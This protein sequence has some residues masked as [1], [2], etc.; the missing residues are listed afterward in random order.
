MQRIADRIG[1]EGTAAGWVKGGALGTSELGAT[2]GVEREGS[3]PAAA[4]GNARS[5]IAA[6]NA[7]M[8]ILGMRVIIRGRRPRDVTRL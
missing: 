2:H 7:A 4:A 3:R 1:D 5:A 6:V 8:R